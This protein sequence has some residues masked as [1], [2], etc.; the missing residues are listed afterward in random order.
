MPHPDY[1]SAQY[2]RINPSPDK[3]RFFAFVGA[4][5]RSLFIKRERLRIG[6]V[7]E[8]ALPIAIHKLKSETLRKSLRVIGKIVNWKVKRFIKTDKKFAAFRKEN[9]DLEEIIHKNE[10]R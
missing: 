1:N 4:I 7:S 6:A 9:P 8:P 3:F 5:F 2:S 10:T